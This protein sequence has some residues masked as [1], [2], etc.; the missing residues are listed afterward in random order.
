MR[1]IVANDKEAAVDVVSRLLLREEIDALDR[2][3]AEARRAETVDAKRIRELEAEIERLED[4]Y[5]ASR[6]AE[7]ERR[8][9]G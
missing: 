1:S 8:F 6:R 5:A 7:I 2:D 3:L 4:R 9:A